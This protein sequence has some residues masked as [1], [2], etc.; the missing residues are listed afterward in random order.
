MIVPS[1]NSTILSQSSNEEIAGAHRDVPFSSAVDSVRG[2]PDSNI[3]LPPKF[4]ASNSP[5]DSAT[6]RNQPVERSDAETRGEGATNKPENEINSEETP[7]SETAPSYVALTLQRLQSKI[8]VVL[9]RKSAPGFLVSL[10]F[11]TSLLLVLA[12]WSV[13]NYGSGGNDFGFIVNVSPVQGDESFQT[14]EQMLS[15]GEVIET[16][17]PS[18]SQSQSVGADARTVELGSMG[19]ELQSLSDSASSGIGA[20]ANQTSS[21]IGE[22]LKSSASSAKAT[23]STTDVEGRRPESRQRLAGQRG[24]NADSEKAVELALE[25]LA[26]H[27]KP[28]GSWSL[29]HTKEECDGTCNHPG[30]PER[31]EPAATGLALLA[32]LG[33]GYTH[34]EGKH[35]ATVKNGVYYLLQI[36]EET[37]HGGSFLFNCPQGMYNHGIATFALCEAYQLSKDESLKS[38]TQ[39]AVD[40]MCFSQNSSGGWGYLPQQPGDL[41]ITGWQ[42]MALKS[43]RAAD[44]Y[45]PLH[46]IVN[47]DKFLDSQT[48]SEMTYYGYTKPG[49]SETCTAIGLMLRMFRNW[50]HTDPRILAGANYLLEQG[51]SS[52][53]VYRNYY[54]TLML[55]HIGGPLFREWNPQMRDSLIRTQV[56]TG[57]GAGSWYFDDK[58]TKVG[59]RMYTTAMAAMTLEVYYRFAPLYMNADTP[60]EF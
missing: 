24:G 7:K 27:Q 2:Q 25:W 19:S 41:T 32:F 39:K 42:T 22:L 45:V 26:A 15:S 37:Q 31:F 51:V 36:M 23:L 29:V 18:S 38:S 3:V 59:G 56:Q 28:N 30:T 16:A 9:G 1:K 60:F 14:V 50:P 5:V 55:F 54:I 33:A 43:A 58:Y 11:H 13:S 47:L 10:I 35:A 40:F 49:K 8:E 12:M 34:R 4:S 6:E 53:D 57:H 20:H 52:H 17:E 46:V 44:L 48:D 21:R